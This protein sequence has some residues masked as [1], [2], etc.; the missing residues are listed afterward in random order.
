MALESRFLGQRF[1]DS[2]THIAFLGF[3][4]RSTRKRLSGEINISSQRTFER[5]ELF[6]GIGMEC[7]KR[8][9]GICVGVGVGV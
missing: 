5:G 9:Y 3:A 1:E 4:G 8:A 2:I 7:L 6:S